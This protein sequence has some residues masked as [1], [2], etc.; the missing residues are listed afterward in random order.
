MIV[1]GVDPGTAITGCAVV[2]S[3]DCGNRLRALDYGCIRTQAD[4]PMQARLLD[5]YTA[6]CNKIH[7]YRAE[8]VAIEQLYFNKNVRT[9]L[10]VG[11]ARGAAILAAANCG[12][13]VAEYT[14]L[15]VKQSV[16]GYGKA[17]K[18]QVQR[19]VKMLLC[20]PEIPCPDDVADALAVAICHSF[21]CGMNAKLSEAGR[22]NL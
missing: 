6:L 8:V 22:V 15:Q 10:A 16:T 9:A 2:E 1:L 18:E 4:A 14:P 7:E 11:Q 19:M 12:L 20:L 3:L 17:K 13:D 5:I 21:S